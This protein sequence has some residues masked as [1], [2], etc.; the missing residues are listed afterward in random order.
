L[1]VLGER[2]LPTLNVDGSRR[3]IRPKLFA[4]RFHHRRRV[5][6]YVLMVLFAV[7][8]FVPVGGKPAVL[9]DVVRREFSL[10]G[11]TFYATDGVLLMLL[12]LS[13]FIGIFWVSALYGRVW[14]GYGCP[15]TVYL[16]FLFRP[17]ER[18][19]EGS[20]GQQQ[21]LDREGANVRRVI[22][23]GIYAL[24]ALLLGNLF[25]S[26]FV[27]VEQL[28]AWLSRSPF[29]HPAPF[30][31]MLV[32]AGLV[33]FDFTY[34]R[35]QMC[36]IV[37]P[38]ARLQSVLLD[39]RS[40]VVGYDRARGEPRGPRK[41]E[42]T[43][44]CI[45][46]KAC[47]VAC[48]TGIDIRDGLQLECVACAQ[49]VDACDGVMAK[50]EKPPGLVRYASQAELEQQPGATSAGAHG[51]RVRTVLYPA[52]VLGLLAALII[53]GSSTAESKVTVLRGTGAPFVVE[54]D[55]RVRNQIRVKIHNRENVPRHFHIALEGAPGSEL[56]AAE[57]PL[58]VASL[59]MA[60][61]SVFVASPKEL[62]SAGRRSVELIVESEGGF[63][64]VTTYNL[65]GPR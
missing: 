24:L 20:R 33:F 45:D 15:Q 59:E 49:C 40:L 37:C 46:C 63:R 36:T 27:G 12:L 25:L 43:G 39:K 17:I 5:V 8:P 6:A 23:Y 2:V 53:L 7:L 30:L 48:P 31:V 1:P 57:N 62:F 42:G 56:V 55:G 14:C 21:K 58:L 47:V 26:Y 61:T 35:E 32:T 11:A 3:W 13:I 50:L 9:L 64:S 51:F 52:L 4:G 44:D 19:L 41:K 10:F 18:W 38:Y 65:M 28:S 60:T 29:E 34:F 54:P 22:K 16:E